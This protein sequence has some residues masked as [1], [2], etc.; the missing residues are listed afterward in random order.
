MTRVTHQMTQRTALAN[1]QTN[2]KA[3]NT[4]QSQASSQKRIEKPS[5]DPAGT[6]QALRLRSEQRAVAQYQ[7]NLEDG[8]SW[9]TTLDTALTTTSSYL[10]RARD[11]VVR[12][13]ND[14]AMGPAQREAI[15]TELEGLRGSLLSQANTTYLGRSVF[16]GT[17]NAGVAFDAADYSFQGTPGSSVERRVSAAVTV[18][19]DGDG[20]AVFGEG[21]DSVFAMLDAIAA[22]LRA[23]VNTS[24]FLTQIDARIDKVLTEASTVGA[25]TNQMTATQ[26]ANASRRLSLGSDLASVEDVDLAETL[27]NVQAQEVAYQAALGAAAK[28]LQPTLLDYLR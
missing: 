15:A 25:R 6:A 24:P 27:V 11:L 16:A 13:A 20:A 5:D 7:R 10:R 2:L 23:G 19:V 18:R 4:L 12:G 3:L 17:S 9:L 8:V 28:A 22:D 21:N 1:I 14:G 26:E